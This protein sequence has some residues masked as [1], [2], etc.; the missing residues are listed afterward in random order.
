MDEQAVAARAAIRAESLAQHG[1]SEAT[2]FDR[3][4]PNQ[5][6]GQV[7]G[8][9]KARKQRV[10]LMP[11][12]SLLTIQERDVIIARFALC[13]SPRYTQVE[14]AAKLGISHQRVSVLEASA[15]ERIRRIAEAVSETPERV[16]G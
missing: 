8:H 16:H 15:L 12:L 10:D 1:L 7:A 6:P 9:A 3:R 11:H 4:R 2:L 14:T 13:G 5:A